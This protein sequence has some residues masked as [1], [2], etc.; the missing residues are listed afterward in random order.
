MGQLSIAQIIV[1]QL[2]IAQI[3]LQ[4]STGVIESFGMDG[5][6]KIRNGPTIRI[7]DPDA[8]YSAG[9]DAI[10]SF[11][12]DNENPSISSFGEFPMCVPRSANDPKCSQSNRPN[13]VLN[14]LNQ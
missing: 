3:F 10:P 8:K 4:A 6:I 13:N 2:S 5:A 7:N 12:A 11:T 9:Y 14:P 1:G